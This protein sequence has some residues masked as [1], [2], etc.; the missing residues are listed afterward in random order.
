MRSYLIDKKYINSSFNDKKVHKLE[1]LDFIL[2]KN[3][4][5]ISKSDV[6][7]YYLRASLTSVYIGIF[8]FYIKLHV[9]IHLI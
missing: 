5:I 9:F 2:I 4:Y 1:L 3:M 6:F 7:A 8:L